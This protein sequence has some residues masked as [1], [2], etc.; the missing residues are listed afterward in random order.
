MSQ[1]CIGSAV[2]RLLAM[3]CF[4]AG[5]VAAVRGS[6]SSSAL[7]QQS[8]FACTEVL[9]FSQSM[10]WYGG[11]AFA[12]R[13]LTRQPID[14]SADVFL[15]RWQ[16]RFTLGGAVEVWANPQNDPWDGNYRS[17]LVCQRE[18]VD[19]VVFV[20][21]GAAKS[22]DEWVR[23][24]SIVAAAI[25]SRYPAARE[26]RHAACCWSRPWTVLERARGIKPDINRRRDWPSSSD[27]RRRYVGAV[28]ESRELFAV[29]RFT[30]APHR[31]R[32]EVCPAKTSRVLQ[33]IATAT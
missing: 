4:I 7:R 5:G 30:G 33:Q 31:G 18:Q 21:S 3:A 27:V 20:V 13:M 22:V 26:D 24:I 1:T 9:G 17:H 29:L 2:V 11:S 6:A 8:A 28:L 25:R 15:P 16:G 19:R 14:L 12:G 10:Q 32:R 23:D